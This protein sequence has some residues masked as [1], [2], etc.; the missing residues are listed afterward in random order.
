MKLKVGDRV[1]RIVCDCTPIKI[2]DVGTIEEVKIVSG[3]DAIKLKEYPHW[4]CESNFEK[5]G[6][7]NSGIIVKYEE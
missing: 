3:I 6:C 1:K 5:A 7:P 2:G 4:F